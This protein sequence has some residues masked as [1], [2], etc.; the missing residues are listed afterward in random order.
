MEK[1]LDGNY[2]RMLWAVMNKSWRQH[3]TK[4]QLY[5]HLPPIT[6]IFKVRIRHTQHCWRS[7]DELKRDYSCGPHHTDDK[8]QDDQQEF[9]CNC[10]VPIQDVCLKTSREQWTTETGAKEGQGESCW[11]CDMVMIYIY[12]YIYMCLCVGQPGKISIMLR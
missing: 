4:Q 3:C 5:G 6:K 8:K 12:I 9:I 2:T 11:Q 1:K 10:S 7:E